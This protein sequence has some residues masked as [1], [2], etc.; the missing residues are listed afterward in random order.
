MKKH[1]IIITIL[2]VILAIES[3][4]LV[5]LFISGPKKTPPPAPVPAVIAGRIAIVLDDWGYNT[6]NLAMLS[7]IRYPLTVSVLPG[8]RYSAF[9]SRELNRRGF[10]VILHLPMEPHEAY[11]LEKNTILS[12]MD[13]AEARRILVI[14]LKSL[15]GV[16]GVSNHMGSRATEDYR[17]MTEVFRELKRRHLY[18]LDSLV[19]SDS[20]CRRA[21]SETGISFAS[22]DIFLDNEEDP[23]YIAAQLRQLANRARLRGYAVGIGHD[24]KNTVKVLRE[25]MPQLAKEGFRFVFVSEVVR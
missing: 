22:R 4:F 23:G 15:S 2:S 14:D 16:K 12:S 6:H 25:M 17:L 20:V 24:R 8:L 13:D 21:A 18:F 7:Q 5:Y 11:R 3:V 19:S 10:E 1:N 9:L